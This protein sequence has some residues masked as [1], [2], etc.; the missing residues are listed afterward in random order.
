MTE[1]D[2]GQDLLPGK[3]RLTRHSSAIML[4]ISAVVGRN[5]CIF[6]KKGPSPCAGYVRS[7]GSLEILAGHTPRVSRETGR[8]A[9]DRGR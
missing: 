6:R 2:A 9:V 5:Y 8:R 4:R 7:P 3:P 1:E